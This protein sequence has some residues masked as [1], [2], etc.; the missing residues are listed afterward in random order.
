MLIVD[1]NN[2]I[3]LSRGDY[4]EICFNLKD[5][6]GEEY[7]LAEGEQVKFGVKIRADFD[8]ELIG[9][10]LSNPGESFV[11][12]I[13]ENADTKNLTFGTYFYDIRLI[14]AD[15]KINT[16]MQ[17]AK[18]EI[19]EVITNVEQQHNSNNQQSAING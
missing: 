13:L 12:V 3:K 7:I 10:T 17:Q 15:G 18:F 2:N 4:A 19:M 11:V 16:P 9:K 1:G 8:T 14:S 6:G 5:D